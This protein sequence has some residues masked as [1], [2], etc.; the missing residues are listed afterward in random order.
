MLKSDLIAILVNK[1]GITQKQAETTVETIFESMTTALCAGDNI[2]IRGLGAFHVKD[3]QGYQG[4]NPKTGQVI[5]VKP[6]RG[7]LFR[8]GKE[9]RER[10]NHGR[11]TSP[12]TEAGSDGAD[13]GDDGDDEGDD[14]GE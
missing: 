10:V 9:L 5:P 13:D 11:T 4:R 7:I 1:R 8:T 14:D 3:Y 12:I 2:E 6:K